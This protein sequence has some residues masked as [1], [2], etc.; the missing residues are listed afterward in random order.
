MVD[1]L[2]FTAS[3][4]W[5]ISGAGENGA[6]SPKAV[7]A[8]QQTTIGSRNI[9]P[10]AVNN[11][12]IMVQTHGTKVHALGYSLDIDS[13][14]GSEISILSEHLFHP[15]TGKIVD[16]AYQQVPDSLLWFSIEDGTMVTCTY[17]PEHEVIGWARQTT[18]GNVTSLACIPGTSDSELWAAIQRNNSE[19]EIERLTPRKH[20]IIIDGTQTYPS[21]VE[22]LRINYDG[23][24]GASFPSKKLISRISV[25]AVRSQEAWVTQ[26]TNESLSKRRKIKWEYSGEMMESNIQIDSG[27]ERAASVR[28]WL[29]SADPLTILA[30][31]PYVTSGA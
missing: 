13:Y 20:E 28:I 7:V 18:S 16:M 24:D 9:Q 29:D 2:A 30:I 31:A 4:E 15:E 6:I 11:R 23:G 27:F 5:K 22:L 19:W 1:L 12:V 21:I 26:G 8:H 17:Q 10:I 14:A 3:G 25:Y